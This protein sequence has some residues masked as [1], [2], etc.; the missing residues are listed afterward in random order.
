MC[1][2][3]FLISCLVVLGLRL[4]NSEGLISL[5]LSMMGVILE[6]CIRLMWVQS[7]GGLGTVPKVV[8]VM[9]FL[10]PFGLCGWT[11]LI[12]NRF[13]M[14]LVLGVSSGFPWT[15][16]ERCLLRQITVA[17]L[18]VLIEVRQGRSTMSCLVVSSVVRR[19]SVC[20]WLL[21]ELV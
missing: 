21:A 9:W 20:V 13:L 6:L 19:L 14:K 17:L 2:S 4:R 5:S 8:P 11:L 3:I 10:L 15:V 18:L 16:R 1:F 7:G 12:V